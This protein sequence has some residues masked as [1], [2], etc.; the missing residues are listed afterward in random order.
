MLPPSTC[1]LNA[2]NLPTCVRL[3]ENQTPR[4]YIKIIVQF[5]VQAADIVYGAS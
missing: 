1:I 4:S 3:L 5:L 2:Q